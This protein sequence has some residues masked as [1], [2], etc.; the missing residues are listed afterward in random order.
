MYLFL[1]VHTNMI[2]IFVK[3]MLYI[4][5]DGLRV[6]FFSFYKCVCVC[7]GVGGRGWFGLADVYIIIDKWKYSFVT[8]ILLIYIYKCIYINIYVCIL[9]R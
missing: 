7:V 8:I 2:L 1:N 9:L 6:L 3:L 4:Y 5:M